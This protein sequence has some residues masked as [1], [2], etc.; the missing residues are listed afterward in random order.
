[1]RQHVLEHRDL[2]A[3]R[4]SLQVRERSQATVEKYLREAEAFLQTLRPGQAVTKELVL[5]WKAALA[6]RYAVSTVNG[7]LAALNG[8]FAFLG[9]RDCQVAPLRRQRTLFRDQRQELTRQEYLRLVEAAHAQGKERLALLLETICAT[10]IRVS[11]LPYITVE[12]ALRGRA[13]IALKGKVR[14]IL[15][16]RK[17]CQR[18]K[19][20]A[21][22]RAI[23]AGVIFRTRSGRP[24]DRKKIWAEMKQLSRQAGVEGSKVFPH[25]LRHLFARC[26]YSAT[27]D[28]A[29][30]ADVLGHSSIETARIYLRTTGADHV[31]TLEK[32]RLIP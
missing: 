11:E 13:E 7:K 18:L 24:L 30:L 9:W 14:T 10:G 22:K 12:A 27:R 8:L 29:Q 16:P 1:M 6:R 32:L 19:K 25:N 2:A 21:R 17:L 3:F 20:Y 5:A 26:F 23:P 31:K 28:V 4:R 15:L